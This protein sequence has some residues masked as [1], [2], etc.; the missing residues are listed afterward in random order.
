MATKLKSLFRVRPL[1][2]ALKA[3]LFAS[4]FFLLFQGGFRLLPVSLF[5]AVA[6]F[7]YFRT[8]APHSFP[9]II[10]FGFLLFSIVLFLPT[11]EQAAPAF[12]WVIL[13]TSS[14][15]LLLGVREFAFAEVRGP[16]GFVT[17]V[18]LYAFL[19]AFFVAEKELFPLLRIAGLLGSHFVLIRSLFEVYAGQD[20]VGEKSAGRQREAR[21][22]LIP[23]VMTLILA[24]LLWVVSAL[25]VT[26]LAAAGL[27]LLTLLMVFE[28]VW[29]VM[30]GVRS[31]K[32]LYQNLS[33]LAGFIIFLLL[34]ATWSP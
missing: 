30:R 4:S 15:Y 34:T 7:L 11:L 28:G 8:P 32:Q 5:I 25:P 3:L 6:C 24:E 22:G 27:S 23:L 18:M 33:I 9:L 20:E 19:T 13:F 21:G 16:Y 2:L 26:P 31:K 12:V 14:F 10:S 29:Y 1:A 17:F